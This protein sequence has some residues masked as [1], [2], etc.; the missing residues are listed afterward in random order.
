MVALFSF[1]GDRLHRRRRPCAADA[2]ESNS[3]I[4]LT[5]SS[6][7]CGGARA[8]TVPT[9]RAGAVRRTLTRPLRISVLKQI[10]G[11]YPREQ[12]IDV[13]L[14]HFP[15]K[16]RK[17]L[18]VTLPLPILHKRLGIAT[19]QKTKL[20]DSREHRRGLGR[21][22]AFVSAL[23]AGAAAEREAPAAR[24]SLSPASLG[25]ATQIPQKAPGPLATIPP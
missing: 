23:S 21:A 2:A 19:G 13:I 7:R 25:V 17:A 18:G 3:G 16:L 5:S 24:L 4:L 12:I 9:R 15:R 22:I 20:E 14:Q 10:E 1:Q 8:G 6:G 11:A